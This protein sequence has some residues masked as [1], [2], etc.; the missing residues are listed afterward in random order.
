MHYSECKDNDCLWLVPPNIQVMICGVKY[1]QQDS[2]GNITLHYVDDTKESAHL[3]GI[4]LG[5]QP[6]FFNI[7]SAVQ[8]KRK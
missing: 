4:N 8:S 5:E 3:P 6:D 1:A 2:Q 7:V